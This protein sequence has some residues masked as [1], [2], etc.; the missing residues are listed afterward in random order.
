M[1]GEPGVVVLDAT[2]QLAAPV[3]DG[4][5]RLASG[6]EG[7]AAGHIP[8]SRHLDLTRRFS[9][10]ANP[11]HFRRLAPADLADRLRRVGVHD[12]ARIVVYDRGGGIWAARVWWMLRAIGVHAQMLDG[13]WQDWLAA[14]AGVQTGARTG[15]PA[16]GDPAN[17]L[18][19]R[20]R[21]GSWSDRSQ[22][23]SIVDDSSLGL[24]VCALGRDAFE[25]RSPTR[26]ARRGHIPGSANLPARSLLDSTGRLLRRPQLRHHLATLL[27]EPRPLVLYCGG[28]ISACLL[29]LGLV[30]AGHE[31]LSVYDG[32]LE[33]WTADA[34]LPVVTVTAG[35]GTA[36]PEGDTP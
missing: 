17:T 32:S 26:Y 21:P 13:G 29:A 10:P 23:C 11:Y 8:G 27:T 25:G 34:R 5:Y 33:E 9:D 31:R 3:T 12:G 24:L 1:L 22:V 18:T 15:R 20:P 30:E 16:G 2:A 6:Y 19:A 4:D 36:P 35:A 14:G 7:W 28:G